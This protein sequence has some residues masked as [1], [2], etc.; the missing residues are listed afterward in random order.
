[1][2]VLVNEY[3]A[4]A[5]EIFS[6]A[7]KDLHRALI[8][9]HRTFGKGSVQNLLGIGNERRAN[10][11]PEAM[12]KLTMA[13]Y[14]LPNGESLHRTDGAKNWGVDP[15]VAVDLTPDQLNDLLKA[16]NDSDIIRRG[17]AATAPA[18]MPATTKGPTPDTQLD[19]ALL[20]M[21]LQLVQSKT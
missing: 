9:G 7:M 8:V 21:R 16:R 5:S 1:M 12:M 3:S 17:G 6:G 15:D 13:K 2:V 10:G 14:Y 4:S 19:T 11:D 18:S 20:M